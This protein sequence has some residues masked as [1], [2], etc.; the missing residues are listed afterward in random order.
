MVQPF[1]LQIGKRN[2]GRGKTTWEVVVPGLNHR[3]NRRKPRKEM[4]GK[5]REKKPH[6][7]K[8]NRD[9]AAKESGNYCKSM[10]SM[11][12]KREKKTILNQGGW[13]NSPEKGWEE[14]EETRSEP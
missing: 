6:I 11:T 3:W 2:Y 13:N 14:E 12:Q 9:T 10:K 5:Q 4:R 7:L 1:L 8:K